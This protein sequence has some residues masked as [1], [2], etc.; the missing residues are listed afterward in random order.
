M[1]GKDPRELREEM[2]HAEGSQK[3]AGPWRDNLYGRIKVSKGTMDKVVIG[4]M[5][6]LLV[7][8]VLGVVTGSR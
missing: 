3:R 4:L 5:V 1:T 7:V 6:L 2:A 8:L